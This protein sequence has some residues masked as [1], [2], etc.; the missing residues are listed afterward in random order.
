[1]GNISFT[2]EDSGIGIIMIDNKK[3]RNV[4]SD[5]VM[6][7]LEKVLYQARS[8]GDKLKA[9]V[10]RSKHP[11]FFSAGGDVKEWYS[12]EKE[13]AYLKGKSGG[14]VFQELENLPVVTIAAISGS[15]LGGGNELAL[16][17][18]YRIA[19]EDA[20]FGQPEVLLGNGLGWGGYYRLVRT[21]G[22]PKAKEM[23][24]FGKTY[25]ATA[26]MEMGLVNQVVPNW[27]ELLKAATNLAEDIA[28]NANTVAIS[29]H[30]LNQIGEQLVPNS[31]LIDAFSAA[32][33][34]ETEN[35]NQRK[36]A[37]INKRLEEELQMQKEELRR[38]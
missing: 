19:T 38:L 14:R 27:T 16:S 26:A 28:I 15:C 36:M 31:S 5:E 11:G 22:L 13:A 18:D 34:A 17:C 33:F 2:L 25:H 30:I 3:K 29:K 4:L 37:F 35:S 20:T 12:Y 32:Y 1:M 21:V 23:I 7:D 8:H 6:I 10:I 9:L 24:L